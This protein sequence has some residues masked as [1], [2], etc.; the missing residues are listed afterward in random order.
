MKTGDQSTS[1]DETASG[2]HAPTGALVGLGMFVLRLYR[3]ATWRPVTA[4]VLSAGL[5]E[6]D[7]SKAGTSYAPRVVY[8][9]SVDGAQYQ[10]GG[11][12]PLTTYGSLQW[13]ESLRDR[14]TP[15]AVVTAYVNPGRPA[16]AYLVREVSFIPLF[17][18]LIPLG[19]AALFAWIVRVQHRQVVLAE[20]HLV[21]V[22]TA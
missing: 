9:Y 20:T 17:L 16:S 3:V 6:S 19:V 15:G 13:A 7:S 18:V 8:R 12:T 14:F 1:R 10:A 2:K 5:R 21:P 22:V 11:V 4:T